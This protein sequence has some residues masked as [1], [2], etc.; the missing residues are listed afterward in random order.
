MSVRVGL[1]DGAIEGVDEG[2]HDVLRFRLAVEA[3]AAGR[4]GRLAHLQ[5]LQPDG[6]GRAVELC[7][8]LSRG[9]AGVQLAAARPLPQQRH[10]GVERGVRHL[11]GRFDRLSAPEKILVQEQILSAINSRP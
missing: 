11:A 9:G 10:G 5:G 1:P 8:S 2:G 6:P 7:D 3:P 4:A